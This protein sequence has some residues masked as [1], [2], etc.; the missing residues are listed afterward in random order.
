[1]GTMTTTTKTDRYGFPITECRRCGGTGRYSFNLMDG[2]RCYGCSG[3][4]FQHTRSAAKLYAEFREAQ[5][6]VSR[7]MARDLQPGDRITFNFLKGAE[8]R[9]VVEV[10]TTDEVCG[11]SLTGTDEAN[12]VYHYYVIVRFD[13]G[14]EE[15]IGGTTLARR[16]GKVDPAP[17]VARVKASR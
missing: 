8:F 11:S 6:A 14:T 13:D 9:N 3:T 12:R 10:I 5:K 7:P 17:F 15:R 2:D 4:G 1:M 16:T